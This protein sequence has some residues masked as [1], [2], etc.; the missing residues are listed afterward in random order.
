MQNVIVANKSFAS[1]LQYTDETNQNL[2]FN[3]LQVAKMIIEIMN[4]LYLSTSLRLFH[5]F[6]YKPQFDCCLIV[7]KFA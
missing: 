3:N 5:I 7:G 1:W 6:F 2:T 4:S